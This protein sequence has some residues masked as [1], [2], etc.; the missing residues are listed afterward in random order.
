MPGAPDPL[1]V[2]A[3]RVLLDALECLSAHLG[4]IVLVGAQA[5]YLHTGESDLNVA[6]F[7]TDGDLAIDPRHLG[8][9]PLLEQ[10]LGQR[11][12]RPGAAVGQWERSIVVDGAP[13][14]VAVDLL[15]PES[16]GGG[17]RR[18]AR[19]P[20]HARRAARK[21]EGLEAAVVDKDFK[22]IAGLES[23]DQ[24]RFDVAV[25]GPAALIVA[26]IHKILDRTDTG[27]RL[28]DK[29]SLDV[30]RLLRAIPTAELVRRF[31]LL[32][33]DDVSLGVTASALRQIPQLF[34]SRSAQGVRMAVRA[35]A[36][37][38]NGDT[39]AA[40]FVV[41]ADELLSELAKG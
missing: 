20:P 3:R 31:H 23:G 25:A 22:A 41:L 29:D 28:R 35:A 26:K 6:P 7:T 5:V 30:Y 40:S 14:V 10:A 1:Y 18:S 12:F 16:L 33:L 4:S 9:E 39:L 15:V 21:A 32:E 38:E 36:P 17:G 13:R 8:G 19:I 37:L 2:A 11:G 34:G 24:R 27:E